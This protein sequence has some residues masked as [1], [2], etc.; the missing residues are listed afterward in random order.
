MTPIL[1]G[2][3]SARDFLSGLQQTSILQQTL[4][5][6][7]QNRASLI[8][9]S[10]LLTTALQA[11]EQ[12]APATLDALTKQLSAL[13]GQPMTVSFSNNVVAEY[14]GRRRPGSARARFPP[15]D[16]R[17]GCGG[18]SLYGGARNDILYG[19]GGNDA[20]YGE[21]GNDLLYGGFGDD[22]LHGG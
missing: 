3:N 12:N 13:L 6:L 2:L 22:A 9:P 20:L 5:G 11:I 19:V 10:S 16:R 15:A 8:D 7:E 1:Q 21:G 14:P 17:S 4:P 18:D